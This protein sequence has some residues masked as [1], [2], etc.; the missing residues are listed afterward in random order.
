MTELLVFAVP[1]LPLLVALAMFAGRSRRW[2]VRV[3][4]VGSVLAAA[5]ALALA[6]DALSNGGHPAV[7]GWYMVDGATGVFLGVIAVVGLL[8]ALASPLYLGDATSRLLRRPRSQ[9]CY[10]VAF[11]VFWAALLLLPLLANLAAAWIVI[12]VT[13]GASALLV[14]YSASPTALEAGWK[15]LV[16]TTFGLAVALLGILV[17]YTSLSAHASVCTRWTGAVSRRRHA[18]HP[19]RG[20]CWRWS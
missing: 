8:S 20:C 6:V 9:H 16:L 7:G 12:E 5:A 1:A 10:Y 2:L 19:T 11:H 18:P 15:Y 17:L 13:T 4:T 3:N 14:A